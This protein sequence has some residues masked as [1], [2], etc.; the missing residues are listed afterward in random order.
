MFK[1]VLISVVIAPVVIGMMAAGSRRQRV[2][3]VVV[4]GLILLYDV[5]YM[6]VFYYLRI[7]WVG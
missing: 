3:L 5:L 4:L 6:V 1:W 7:R 2:G